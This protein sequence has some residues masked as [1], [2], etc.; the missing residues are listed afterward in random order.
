MPYLG[1]SLR[2]VTLELSLRPF[3]DT[4]EEG[5]RKVLRGM[6]RQWRPLARHADTASVMMWTSD[7][8]EI[9]D[10]TGDLDRTFEWSYTI[11]TANPH[12]EAHDANDPKNISIHR[13][14][15]TY[16]ENPPLHTYR[17][18]KRFLELVKEVGA[19][20][21]ERPVTLGATFDP[22]PE[23]AKSIF[24]Y[25]KH[26]EICL[27]GTMGHA[28][29]VTCYATLHAD[30]AEYAGFPDG[31]P[32]GTPFGTFLGRQSR[33][34]LKAMGFDWLWLSNGFGF[35][36][37]T[38]GMYGVVFDGKRYDP[39]KAAEV[40]DKSLAF[41]KAFRKECPDV[42]L[43]SRGTNQTTGRDLA[44]DGVPLREIYRGG[45]NLEPAVNSPWAAL[46]GDFGLELT[47]WMSHI[48]QIPGTTYPY[49]FYTHDN[50]FVNSP[51]IDR[52]G[53][54]PH[55]IHLPLSVCRL[56]GDGKVSLPTD[57]NILSVD[58]TYGKMPDLVPNEVI[59][60]ILEDVGTSPD[61]AGPLVWVYPF[62]EYHDM[63]LDAGRIPEVFFGD[64]FMRTSVNHGLPLNTVVS[65]AHFAE[66]EE[67]GKGAFAGRV[68]VTPA[69]I[70]KRAAERVADHVKRGG[71]ALLYGPTRHADAALLELLGLKQD[72]PISGEL[73][74]DVK[75]AT[76]ALT[77]SKRPARL[78]HHELS[79][80][81]GVAEI[82]ADAKDPRTE[83]AATVS[84]KGQVRAYALVRRDPAWKGGALAWVRGTNSFRLP[85]F[86]GAH[87][88]EMH[89][90][91]AVFY[92]EL[93]S[94]HLLSAF[95]YSLALEK[96]EGKQKNPIL[97]VSRHRNA[98]YFAGHSPNI[99]VGQSLRFPEGAPL[100]TGQETW[101]Q[102]GSSTWR[103]PKAWRRECR[104]FVEQA[105]DGELACIEECSIMVGVKRR[106]RV[107][108]LKDAVVRFF[109]ETGTE[110]NVAILRNGHHPYLVGDFATPAREERA[111]GLALRVEHVTGDL[112][113]S[114]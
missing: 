14:P 20:E 86:K 49:R 55:D 8:S 80:A 27:G 60:F 90:P 40:K 24:K 63:A 76:D 44:S 13:H 47:G 46:N 37:E 5:V 54:E 92:S 102:N 10:F 43:R 7:G 75:L 110:G 93:L 100:L 84:S 56:E 53:R 62:D 16:I 52:Y 81:G 12:V 108:G 23:F 42:W 79:S 64:W 34:F 112:I 1:R 36:L 21:L 22:G 91:D 4:T 35:G 39:A 28:S 29:M 109:P 104:V 72:A 71:H 95:G 30:K 78:I 58:D 57:I 6:F 99:T 89:D 82:L 88:P 19:Q 33:H 67:A 106:L 25:Q 31:I 9:L 111:S 70:G 94:R 83:L 32:E 87:L 59:P 41:F 2:S 77:A 17:W 73:E 74:I 11:G 113:I 66:A 98:F 26:P 50:W 105:A 48:A 103:M 61:A 96:R 101:I 18:Y 97:V 85:E 68:L 38:W 51:W 65:T 3:V 69:A 45:F 107:K 15:Y 114:W